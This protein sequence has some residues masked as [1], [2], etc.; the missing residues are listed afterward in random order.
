MTKVN[1]QN[2]KIYKIYYLDDPNECYIGSTTKTLNERLSGHILS[3]N[4][5]KETYG[6][7]FYKFV[8]TH[9]GFNKFKMILLEEYP[10]NSKLELVS[11]E[12]YWMRKENSTLNGMKPSLLE[13]LVFKEFEAICCVCGE[14]YKLTINNEHSYS[15]YHKQKLLES[16]ISEKNEL[17]QKLKECEKRLDN[18][19]KR[20]KDL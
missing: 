2:G 5:C 10:C 1:Y 4:I 12:S 19:I 13:N 20:K 6:C 16:I 9:G 15:E 18:E 11:R 7:K 8:M 14:K 17:L 3:S